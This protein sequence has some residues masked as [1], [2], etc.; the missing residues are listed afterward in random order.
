MSKYDQYEYETDGDWPNEVGLEFP[1][2]G[3]DSVTGPVT[4]PSVRLDRL[5]DGV[6]DNN[7][8]EEVDA[9]LP[10]GLEVR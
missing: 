2:R 4:G 8:H 10:T 5:L 7:R 1:F 3:N 9:G 6:T